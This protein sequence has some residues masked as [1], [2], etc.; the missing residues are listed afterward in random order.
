MRPPIP[1]RRALAATALALCAALTACGGDD[2]GADEPSGSV[3][4]DADGG[5]NPTVPEECAEPFP[6]AFGEGDL[7]N[8][9]LK[10]SDWP[11]PF[12]DPILCGTSATLDE[13]QQEADFAVAA[14]EAEV[15]S[16]FETALS[17]LDG[18]QVAREDPSGLGRQMLSGSVGD[19][20]FQVLAVAG[21][22]TLA[23]A[24]ESA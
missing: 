6:L 18:Y 19:V 15:L 23:F 11:E 8:L 9:T 10:P 14:D 20:Y 16:A 13:S 12:A 21:G 17:T 3:A 22:Y 2:S 4:A 5:E 1:H 7:D 24:R